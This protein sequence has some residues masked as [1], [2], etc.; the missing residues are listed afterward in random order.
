VCD[1]TNIQVTAKDAGMINGTTTNWTSSV[2]HFEPPKVAKPTLKDENPT[3]KIGRTNFKA[4]FPTF[5]VNV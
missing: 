3:V 4:D 2:H 1:V 5:T